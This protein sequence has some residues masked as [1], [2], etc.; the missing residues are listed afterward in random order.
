MTTYFIWL[1]LVPMLLLA[2]AKTED[3]NSRATDWETMDFVMIF[4]PILNLLAVLLSLGMI[5]YTLYDDPKYF[6]RKS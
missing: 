5:L 6:F 3:V 2:F 1:Y 4:A